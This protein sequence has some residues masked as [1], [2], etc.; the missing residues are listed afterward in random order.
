MQ[1]T[2]KQRYQNDVQSTDL[3]FTQPGYSRKDGVHRIQSYFLSNHLAKLYE[4]VICC[5][6][7]RLFTINVSESRQ[8]LSLLFF[9]L[10]T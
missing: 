2:I 4:I 1:H 5:C 3:Y 8:L 7:V 9:L 10:K 6:H